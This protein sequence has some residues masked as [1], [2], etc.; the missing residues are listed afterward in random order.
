MLIDHLDSLF[1]E[2]PVWIFCFF[3]SF[4][5]NVLFIRFLKNFFWI[6]VIGQISVLQMASY[7]LPCLFENV[8]FFFF[9]QMDDTDFNMAPFLY[10]ERFLGSVYNLLW[11]HENVQYFF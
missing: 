3:F 6:W 10:D 4:E 1:C 11:H 5:L 7:T 2:V 8:F 9:Q